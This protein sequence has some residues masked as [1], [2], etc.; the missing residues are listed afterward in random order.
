MERARKVLLP[1][2]QERHFGT[3]YRSLKN[4]RE[5]EKVSSL[6][7]L[8]PFFDQDDLIRAGGFVKEVGLGTSL[9]DSTI[10]E[11]MEQIH[12]HL[13]PGQMLPV[14]PDNILMAYQLMKGEGTIV[15]DHVIIKVNFPLISSQVLDIYKLTPIPFL[16]KDEI[17]SIEIKSPFLKQT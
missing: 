12:S 3:E 8:T 9:I 6:S 17:H 2:I 1:I 16:G 7:T 15:K 14:H 5:V 13:R 4:C 11:Q 10:N